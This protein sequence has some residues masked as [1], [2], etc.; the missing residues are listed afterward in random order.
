[1]SKNQGIM[2]ITVILLL[3]LFFAGSQ[4]TWAQLKPASRYKSVY[5]TESYET[6]GM[7]RIGL[8]WANKTI[9]VANGGQA[10]S[11][12]TLTKAF[13][14]VWP[15]YVVEGILKQAA[16]P[17]FKEAKDEEYGGS[18][19]VDRSNG[20]LCEDAGYSD[21]ESMEACVWKRDNGH[22][23]FAIQVSSSCDPDFSV[24][25]F[26]DYNPDTQTL[27]PEP[28]PVDTY[29]PKEGRDYWFK[30]PRQGKDFIITEMIHNDKVNLS[31]IYKFDGK[32]HV[33]SSQKSEPYD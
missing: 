19:V 2:R 18:T 3:T 16:N 13:N 10:P 28:S 26:Y 11:I 17:N 24:I 20:Y 22:R 30:L 1:M 14:S 5:E 12:I 23:L 32:K 6:D 27:T 33:Y 29:K 4:A 15:T 8:G 9:K 7:I 31:S 21:S 25:C